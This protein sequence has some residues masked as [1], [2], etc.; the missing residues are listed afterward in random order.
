MRSNPLQLNG[1]RK[2]EG[3]ELLQFFKKYPEIIPRQSYPS[4]VYF[5]LNLDNFIIAYKQWLAFALHEAD[6]LKTRGWYKYDVN[7][8]ELQDLY[9]GLI[10]VLEQQI[11]SR[12]LK[13][14]KNPAL[15]TILQRTIAFRDIIKGLSDKILQNRPTLNSPC[16]NCESLKDNNKKCRRNIYVSTDNKLDLSLAGHGVSFADKKDQIDAI[17]GNNLKSDQKPIILHPS[18]DRLQLEEVMYDEEVIQRCGFQLFKFYDQKN[19]SKLLDFWVYNPFPNVIFKLLLE[20]HEGLRELNLKSLKRGSQFEFFSQGTMVPRGS[21][22]AMGG[23]PGDAYVMYP[24]MEGLD[25]EGINV[26]FN[27]AETSM[28]L[29]EA[30]RI[31]SFDHF[32]A[33]DKASKEGDRL[34]TSGATTYHCNNYTAPLHKDNDTVPG[35]C[36]QYQLQA[37]KDLKEFSFIYGD[38]RKY[39]VARTNSLWSFS[40]SNMHGTMLPSTLPL[41]PEDIT[42]KSPQDSGQQPPRVSNGDHRTETKRNNIAAKKYQTVRVCRQQI[43]RYWNL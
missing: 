1:P 33:L 12:Q 7:E 34:G 5:L 13:Y 39:V 25:S 30:A 8:N 37:R 16:P 42:I 24:G 32:T 21:R 26:L 6:Q 35:I 11:R 18:D 14:Y 31:F 9:S 38:Y 15:E 19:P 20:H 41:R 29:S 27:D 10:R 22:I 36:S 17:P 2:L 23:L 28:I 43:Y 3:K 4:S 40:G